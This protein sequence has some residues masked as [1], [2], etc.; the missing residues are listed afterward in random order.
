[1][2]SRRAP[3]GG[4]GQ[5]YGSD[6][7][8][9]LYILRERQNFT[10]LLRNR[11]FNFADIRWRKYQCASGLGYHTI[12][13]GTTEDPCTKLVSST[14]GNE[15]FKPGSTVLTASNTGDRKQVIIG[16][17]PPGQKGASSYPPLVAAFEMAAFAIISADP[18]VIGANDV[19]VSRITGFGFDGTEVFTCV[20]YNESTMEYDEDP[21]VTVTDQTY[22]DTENWDIE[23]TADAATPVGYLITIRAER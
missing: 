14:V 18:D 20:V 12:N 19:T 15:T 6:R 1:M 9:N 16:K 23:F 11:R 4:F 13:S 7:N 22:V 21:Y 2:P 8:H 3:A 17:P 10:R 5:R